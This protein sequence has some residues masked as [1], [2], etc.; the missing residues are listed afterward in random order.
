MWNAFA[1]NCSPCLTKAEVLTAAEFRSRSRS[2]WLFG[3]G[4]GAALFAG[5]MLAMVVG[6]VDGRADALFKHQGAL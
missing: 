1:A 6:T 5:A 3:T 2:F 4:A